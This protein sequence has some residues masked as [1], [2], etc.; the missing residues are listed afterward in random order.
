MT[1]AMDAA[2]FRAELQAER[3]ARST[4]VPGR[5]RHPLLAVAVL[6]GVCLLALRDPIT[7]HF[8]PGELIRPI[9]SDLQTGA[10]F[11]GTFLGVLAA[12]CVAMRPVA[13]DGRSRRLGYMAAALI[14]PILFATAAMRWSVQAFAFAGLTPTPFPADFTVVG[15]GSSDEGGYWLRLR[16][17]DA[18]RV[19]SLP[20]F[21]DVYDK[22]L[23]GDRVTLPVETGRRGIRR[24][25]PG[26]VLRAAD[27]R[28][29]A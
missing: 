14:V 5:R 16:Q 21:D 8:W 20:V 29:P 10:I 19:F 22:A 6:A 11:A 12:A 18:G 25:M 26:R 24:M 3:E 17:G 13:A 2:G 23:V 27:L 28:H 7:R 4:P 9:D 15:T 1:I